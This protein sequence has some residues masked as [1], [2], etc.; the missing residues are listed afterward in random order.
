MLG[1]RSAGA[2][3][4]EHAELAATAAR[5]I[6]APSTPRRGA[7]EREE[8]EVAGALARIGQELIA[9]VD[10]P[11]LLDRLCRVTTD[12]LQC[13]V[14]FT[15]L[16]R[17]EEDVY[18]PVASVG[19]TPER[20]AVVRALRVAREMVPARNE[21]NG[22]DDIV[23][24]TA[25]AEGRAAPELL[26][27]YDVR[28][29]LAVGLRRGRQLAGVH[30]AA[31]RTPG[32]TFGPRQHRIA[33]GL[34]RLASLALENARQFDKLEGANQL[35]SVFLAT[36]SHELR[37]PLSVITGYVEL[38]LDEVFGRLTPEQTASLDR[39][40]TSARELLEL[41][42]A[43][44]GISRLETGRTA[45]TLQEIHPAALLRE[46]EAETA[47]TRDKPEVASLWHVPDDLPTV[48]S[49]AVK[50]KVLLKNLI[51]N[52]FKFTDAGSVTVRA[53]ARDDW[54]ELCVTDTGIGMSPAVQAVIFEP[55]RQGDSSTARRRG[56]VGLGLYI[57]S[58]LLD[59]LA[60][61]IEVES[62]PG[63]GS[64]FRVWIPR[65]ALRPVHLATTPP[66][67]LT[68]AAD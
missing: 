59:M 29:L 22:H 27:D 23:H 4:A 12:V 24:A 6:A 9:S 39:V 54:L 7:R 60:G 51:N 34:A 40:G 50:L 10:L 62:A 19:Y 16:Y 66:P 48:Y 13:D 45:L 8:G 64:T 26:A 18:V 38:L 58:R 5:Q 1:S 53:A 31:Q 57:L 3:D 41:I 32:R 56:G 65:D 17:E 20:W 25:D 55:F 28:E 35:K 21:P 33:R 43:T 15:M 42:N 14:A 44:L 52:A 46:V 30:V 61:R 68:P 47:A 36:M 37:T 2:L 67:P 49:D 63:K 11:V